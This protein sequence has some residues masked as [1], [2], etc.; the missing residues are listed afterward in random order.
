MWSAPP[1]ISSDFVCCTG[2]TALVWTKG[3]DPCHGQRGKPVPSCRIARAT[4][5]ARPMESRGRSGGRL[6]GRLL[7]HRL[8]ILDQPEQELGRCMGVIQDTPVSQG[9]GPSKSASKRGASSV[10]PAT[11]RL[12]APRPTRN[13][14]SLA[15]SIEASTSLVFPAPALPSITTAPPVPTLT[16]L[17]SN[18]R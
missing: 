8:Q 2:A 4:T 7:D 18:A 16:S 3:E 17:K 6:E 11:L 10:G 9:R 5:G 14:R 12:P 15:S 1:S 13:P